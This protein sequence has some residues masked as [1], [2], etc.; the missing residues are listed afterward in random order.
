MTRL[1]AYLLPTEKQAP[2]DAEAISH[3]LMVRAGLIRQL[4]AGLW[5]YLPAGWKI[6]RKIEQIIREEMDAI[7][8]QELLMPLLNP[9]EP[10]R[11]TGRIEIEEIFK[12]ADRKGTEMV[13]AMTHEEIITTHVAQVVR[14]Y[15]DLPQILY[16]I[17]VKERDEARPRAGVLR[18]REFR[19]KDSYSFDRDEE[20]L[21]RSYAAHITAYDRIFDR[22]GLEWYRVESDVGMMGGTAAHEYMAP[23]AAG[24]DEVALAP[25]YAA[26]VEI[27]SADPQ[28]VELPAPLPQ[29]QEEH[30]PGITTVEDVA[31]RLSVP[32]GGVLKAYPVIA[33]G[34]GLVLVLVRGDHR[35]NE[36]KLRNALR[37]ECRPATA[38]EFAR[39][40]G[41]A[42]FIGPV[43]ANAPIVLDD[44]VGDGGYVTGANR[45]DH[46]LR[47]VE[48]GRDF[49]FERADVRAVEPGDTVNGNPI[50]I[51]KAI[52][53]GNIFKLG[54]RYS[55]ALGAHYL[56]E[57][58]RQQPIVMG[59]Y[60]I[61]PARIAAAAVEQFHDEAGIAW[62][63]ALAPF[64]V[65]LVVISRGE[66][67]ERTYADGLYEQL[68]EIGLDVL[69]D[70][71]DAG[72]GEK[73]AD[74]ELLGAPLRVTVGRR[75]L[76]AGELEVQLRRG[77]ESRSIPL[78]GAAEA[79]R[80]LWR[81][82][83]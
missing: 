83:P 44:A 43:G 6:H 57:S 30:T 61:G 49:P 33:E 7:G 22:S 31:R 35:V 62:P 75:T 38:D 27:A 13:L 3:K 65:E 81:T 37:S 16:Q 59:C 21:E 50:R 23:C 9:A 39:K 54:T 36:T 15:R 72:P 10:W 25:G 63:R 12:L 78:D 68:R 60:G 73:F 1:S 41:P 24:E 67:E 17:Q 32:A 64:D 48:P 29:P 11:R 19:M 5:T 82:L 42:G 55:T 18:T 66:S 20:G 45:A 2:A 46:H 28:P 52:E 40:I 76:A 14:S 71:R 51:E 56:D 8:G 53:I 69:Y 70:D 26:N 77:R 34:R 58:G 79:V 4:G 47:G 80:E 74:A